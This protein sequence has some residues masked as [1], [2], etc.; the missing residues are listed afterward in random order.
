MAVQT[1]TAPHILKRLLTGEMLF[2]MGDVGRA[3]LIQ[4]ELVPMA[5]PGHSHGYVEANF[6]GILREFV[7]RHNL[8]RVL[9]G[10]TGLYTTHNPD[11][12]RGMDAAFISHERFARVQSPSYLDVAPELIVEI[13]SPGD[14]LSQLEEKLAE[15]FA[16]GVLVVWMA[17]PRRREVTVYRSPTDVERLIADDTLTGGKVLPDF[18]VT[19]AE[20]FA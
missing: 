12:V 8:G 20:L 4:G 18:R 5:P 19:V 3:E 1:L 14:R 9:G 16:M 7:R 11:T 6:V 15:Y 10:E 13:L 17:D 2:K